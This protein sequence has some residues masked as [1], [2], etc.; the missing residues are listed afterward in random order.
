AWMLWR[1]AW[2]QELPAPPG[3]FTLAFFLLALATV[4]GTARRRWR[5][6]GMLLSVPVIVLALL[7]L[8]GTW[9]PGLSSMQMSLGYH[10]RTAE[11]VIFLAAT[12]SF[13]LSRTP[14]RGEELIPHRMLALVLCGVRAYA[15]SW[16][17]LSMHADATQRRQ[18]SL[19][20]RG[21]QDTLSNTM[22]AQ[23][24]LI[25]RMAE[26]WNAADA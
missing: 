25:N 2:T 5:L 6:A 22:R 26:R 16:V 4:P 3:A 13:L 17:L 20:L 18:T 7:S 21:L 11:T 12:A 19:L 8:A 15:G 24:T 10:V 1:Y 14:A 9:R 23:L